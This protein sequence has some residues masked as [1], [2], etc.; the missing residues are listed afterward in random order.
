MLIYGF[1]RYNLFVHHYRDHLKQDSQSM[2]FDA[3]LSITIDT[4]LSICC[5]VWQSKYFLSFHFGNP[6]RHGSLYQGPLRTKKDTSSVSN[7]ILLCYQKH[8]KCLILFLVTPK[9]STRNTLVSYL[10]LRNP[11][12]KPPWRHGFPKWNDSIWFTCQTLQD[13]ESRASTVMEC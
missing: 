3:L 7:R 12:Y 8:N 6:W 5:S 4:L 9:Y 2:N 1:N 11:W 13:M 10:D